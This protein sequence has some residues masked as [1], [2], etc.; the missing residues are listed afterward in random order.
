MHRFLAFD[1]LAEYIESDQPLCCE[2]P[3][4][5]EASSAVTG[6]ARDDFA[7]GYA[8]F[9]EVRSAAITNFCKC[10]R[11]A[12]AS[13]EEVSRSSLGVIG[14]AFANV[15]DWESIGLAQISSNSTGNCISINHESPF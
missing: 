3:H 14:W 5:P 15:P 11:R 6:P 9:L 10:H 12:D 2:A 4:L 1:E 8:H 7:A 13:L